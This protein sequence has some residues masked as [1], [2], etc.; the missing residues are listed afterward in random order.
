MNALEIVTFASIALFAGFYAAYYITCFVYIRKKP[1][2]NS[3]FEEQELPVVSLIVPVY[4]E[5]KIIQR[6]IDNLQTIDYPRGKLEVVFVDG[7]SKDGT[8]EKIED[9]SKT[10]SYSQRIVKQG[11]RKGFNSAVVEGF[12]QTT[13]EV[14][15]ITGA[16]T[17][18]APDA[19]RMIVDHF[20]NP[21]VGA[22]N[23]TMKINNLGAGSST[24]IEA[25]Y[26]S[27]YDF[28]REAESKIDS[29]FD[30]K[31]EIAATRR[32][33]CQ[34]I[35]GKEGILRK[36]CIDAC[37][38][39][40]AAEEG[41]RTVYEP[42]AVY[43][44]PAPETMRDSF[45]QQIRRGATLIENMLSYKNMILRRKYGKFGSVI[46]PAHFMML[47]VLPFFFFI[48]VSGVLLL[49]VF[50]P[51][52]YF[53]IGAIILGLIGLVFSRTVQAFVKVQLVLI[54]TV[55]RVLFRK[56]NQKFERLSSVRPS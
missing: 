20:A 11:S 40:Q 14:I 35:V 23:G 46:M 52:N 48:S 30:I 50:A 2:D 39:F 37:F 21:K 18:Y 10:I 56:D 27:F 29:P 43:S 49:T 7:G 9:S 25:S 15:I 12:L 19:V 28:V 47:I 42:R 26:R 44:E 24:Q 33:I 41:C 32:S 13:G 53:L 51:P 31:G 36:G 17:E 55:F 16:E 1:F 8:V 54:L 4:N 34:H 3:H 6:K 5:A 22:V 38:S 45:K